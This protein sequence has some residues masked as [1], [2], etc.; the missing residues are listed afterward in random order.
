[1]IS[2]SV[3]IEAYS[4]LCL[5]ELNLYFSYFLYAS[6]KIIKPMVTII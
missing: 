5:I 2:Y 3:S 4:K 6:V 1:M